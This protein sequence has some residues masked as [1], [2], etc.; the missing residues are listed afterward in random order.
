M[1]EEVSLAKETPLTEE[2]SLAKETPLTEEVSLAKETPLTREERKELTRYLITG[3]CTD[4]DVWLADWRKLPENL[5]GRW[6]LWQNLNMYWIMRSAVNHELRMVNQEDPTASSDREILNLIGQAEEFYEYCEQ[7]LK[8]LLGEE[9]Y[10]PEDE[11]D[12]Y[13]PRWEELRET[14]TPEELAKYRRDIDLRYPPLSR[15]ENPGPPPGFSLLWF[16]E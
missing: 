15:L 1:P 14:L 7:R 4:Y 5:R 12:P 6:L 9:Y 11:E 2:V 10:D 16:Q 8:W 3:L 13:E